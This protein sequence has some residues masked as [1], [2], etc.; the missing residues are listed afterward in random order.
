MYSWDGTWDAASAD[1]ELGAVI[2]LE[3][4]SGAVETG[5]G[6]AGREL[7]AGE[8]MER[9]EYIYPSQPK[10]FFPDA[11]RFDADYSGYAVYDLGGAY[12]SLHLYLLPDRI[13]PNT[14]AA[15]AF[16][17]DGRLLKD[18][19]GIVSGSGLK[20]VSVD[21]NGVREL[22]VRTWRSAGD[23]SAE[24]LV[25]GESLTA[26]PSHDAAEKVRLDSQVKVD[27]KDIEEGNGRLFVDVTGVPHDGYVALRTD[28]DAYVLYNIAGNYTE[29]SGTIAAGRK[30]PVNGGVTVRVLLDNEEVLVLEDYGKLSGAVPFTFDVTGVQTIRFEAVSEENDSWIFITDDR[31]EKSAGRRRESPGLH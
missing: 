27:S 15:I 5:A 1:L 8:N 4:L 30:T 6:L 23:G 7:L 28:S 12:D 25:F 21:V 20:E 13:D 26:A 22:T 18:V 9:T 19:S 24:I 29:F 31:L 3:A 17:G 16:F 2:Q 14:E 10:L 11:L